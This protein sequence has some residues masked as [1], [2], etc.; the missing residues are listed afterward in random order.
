MPGIGNILRHGVVGLLLSFSV[1][2]NA[3]EAFAQTPIE[4]PEIF[5]GIPSPTYLWEPVQG[6][7]TAIIIGLHGGVLHGRS[8]QGLATELSKKGIMFA[9]LDLRGYGKWRYENFGSK[10]DQKIRYKDSMKDAES[11]LVRLHHRYPNTAI[12]CLGESLGSQIA[13]KMASKTPELIDGVVAISPFSNLSGFLS[14]RMLIN[15]LQIATHPKGKLDLKPYLKQKLSENAEEVAFQ[16]ADPLNRNKQSIGEI[17]TTLRM[18]LSGEKA[19][20]KLPVS[21]PL[22]IVVGDK[23]NLAGYKGTV[24]AF[25]RMNGINKQLAV[26]KGSGHLIAEASKPEARTIN[27]LNDFVENVSSGRIAMKHSSESVTA[28][29]SFVKTVEPTAND[30]IVPDSKSL[31][32]GKLSADASL[33]Q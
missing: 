25:K 6:D 15:G 8:Y 1:L 27:V 31:A 18:T 26:L 24:K 9:S 5:R 4:Q 10:R 19:A 17:L 2:L 13:F 11:M 30:P 32:A 22:L 16:F 14:P 29:S 21:M 28:D 20:F 12:I 7:P 3:R 23:D 33:L